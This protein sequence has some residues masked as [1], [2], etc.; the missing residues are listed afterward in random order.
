MGVGDGG[1]ER[2]ARRRR[3][4][5]I[6]H[7]GVGVSLVRRDPRSG[8]GMTEPFQKGCSSISAV[9]AVAHAPPLGP[10][11]KGSPG[12]RCVGFRFA[13]R[14]PIG[15][16]MT[17][18]LGAISEGGCSCGRIRATR[19]P[20]SGDHKGSPL[21]G[22]GRGGAMVN[23]GLRRIRA[24]RTPPSG[25]HKGSPLHGTRRRGP[26]GSTPLTLDARARR[27]PSR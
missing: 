27:E 4:P 20:P 11:H 14:S 25:D 26:R 22:T 13:A 16:G 12:R 15:P 17:D 19:T 6:W 7:V 9:E 5:A 23:R 3:D 24:T 2:D 21:H 10:G 18:I 1:C 8:W